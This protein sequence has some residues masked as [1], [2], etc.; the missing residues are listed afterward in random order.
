[1]REEARKFHEEC[2]SLN[3]NQ[4]TA[5]TYLVFLAWFFQETVSERE[6]SK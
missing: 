5:I 6:H 1:M 3:C 4:E 2:G